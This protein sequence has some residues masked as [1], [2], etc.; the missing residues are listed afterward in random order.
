[1]GPLMRAE[2]GDTIVVTLLNN[3]SFPIN[4]VPA[5]LE[6]SATVAGLEAGP[7]KTVIYTWTVPEQVGSPLNAFTSFLHKLQ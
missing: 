1:M 7:K 6:Y 5:G 3:L 4:L 2:V